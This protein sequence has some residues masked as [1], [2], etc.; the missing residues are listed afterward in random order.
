MKRSGSSVEPDTY[1]SVP[2][3]RCRWSR[4]P[5]SQ[6]ELNGF[7]AMPILAGAPAALE[8]APVA[9]L[10]EGVR[11]AIDRRLGVVRADQLHADRQPGRQAAR[12]VHRRMAADVER[13]GIGQHL[14]GALAV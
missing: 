14:E 4:P 9:E 7:A 11:G 3:G 10:L 2:G 1:E 6:S 5:A 13:R 8:V 12:H